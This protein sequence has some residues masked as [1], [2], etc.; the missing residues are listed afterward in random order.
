MI[1]ASEDFRR[2]LEGYGLTVARIWYCFPDNPE[3][4]NPRWMLWQFDDIYPRFPRLMTFLHFWPEKIEGPLH[5]VEVM[6]SKLIK[7]AEIRLIDGD[8]KFN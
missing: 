2:K 1:S 4:I 3:V 5:S 7:P 6:H 8:F